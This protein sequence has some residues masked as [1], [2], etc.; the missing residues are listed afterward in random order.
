MAKYVTRMEADKKQCPVLLSN[1]NLV[2]EGDL[3][4]GRWGQPHVL[5]S[6]E[7]ALG[8][9][10]LHSSWQLLSL[11]QSTMPLA[12]SPQLVCLTSH[13]RDSAVSSALRIAVGHSIVIVFT[14]DHC[15][16]YGRKQ[17]H[18]LCCQVL[19][20][21][22]AGILQSGRTHSRSLAICLL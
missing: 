3:D 12:L 18:S 1:G 17:Q 11:T 9:A 20:L 21:W 2:D 15:D 19:L 22:A 4:G 5:K 7:R 6:S 16:G 13:S 10:A 8:L 14:F